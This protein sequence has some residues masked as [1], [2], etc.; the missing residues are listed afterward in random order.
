MVYELPQSQISSDLYNSLG[1]IK[2]KAL[3][4]SFTNATAQWLGLSSNS[5]PN[6]ATASKIQKIN[7]NMITSLQNQILAYGTKEFAE[8]YR[9]FMLYHWRNSSK[10]VIRRVNN[11]LSWTYKKVSKK[12]IKWDFSIM[13][14]DPI[15]KAIMYDEKKSAYIEQYNMLV[16]DQ[17]T[18]PFLLNNIRRAI[19]YYNWLDES[20]IDSIT[21]LQPEEYQC[22]MDVLLLNQDVSV[23]IPQNA[24]IQMR[25][26]YYNRAEDTD[27]KFRAIQALQYMVQQWLGTE[28]MNMAEQTKVTD[29]KSAWEDNNPLT[30]INYGTVDNL[31]SWTWMSEWSRANRS[32][33][34]E[35]LNVWGMQSLDVSNGV[36]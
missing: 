23:Y 10:K 9:E 24:N 7:A 36:G 3:A 22:K 14:I 33:K 30:S 1:M 5:D 27:A 29:F 13:V 32:N 16:N 8:L 25:L 21:E 28:Q 15:L 17:R 26:W 12:D 11:W 18:P 34:R 4:E 35:N 19:A 6:T 20:E 2:N 31:D